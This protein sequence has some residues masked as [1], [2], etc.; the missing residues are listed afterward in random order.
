MQA[1]PAAY[2]AALDGPKIL[3][4]RFVEAFSHDDGS[5]LVSDSVDKA[6]SHALDH[7]DEVGS[8]AIAPPEKELVGAKSLA[9]DRLSIIFGG[10]RKE[11]RIA[12]LLNC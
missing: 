10:F 12:H 11:G 8:L 2:I 7:R 1:I 4:A 5:H 9:S 6:A 3:Q